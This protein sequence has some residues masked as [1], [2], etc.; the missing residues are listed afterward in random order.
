V[1]FIALLYVA[2]CSGTVDMIMVM[3]KLFPEKKK[4]IVIFQKKKKNKKANHKNTVRFHT[5][6]YPAINGNSQ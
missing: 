4:K 3:V 1:T 6:R 2:T 5:K